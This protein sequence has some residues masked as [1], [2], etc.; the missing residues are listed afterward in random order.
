[1]AVVVVLYHFFFA[2]FEYIV[3][4]FKTGELKVIQDND[5]CHILTKI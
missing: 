4:I 1:M 2:S 5:S 3:Y